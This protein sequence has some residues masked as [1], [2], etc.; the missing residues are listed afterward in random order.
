MLIAML[1]SDN[2]KIGGRRGDPHP[3]AVK[4]IAYG[5]ARRHRPAA[6]PSGRGRLR[7]IRADA[8][9][10]PHTRCMIWTAGTLTLYVG[11]AV[12]NKFYR[13]LALP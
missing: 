7:G 12:S 9:G 10:S 3:H 1:S 11:G 13:A 2:P 4:V 5:A 8:G 6:I